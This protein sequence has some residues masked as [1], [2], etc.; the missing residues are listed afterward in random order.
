MGE[1]GN[2]FE[3]NAKEDRV[4]LAVALDLVHGSWNAGDNALAY[5]LGQAA[6]LWKD[7]VQVTSDLLLSQ[8]QL[9]EYI[10][11]A[12]AKFLE[13]HRFSIYAGGELKCA[14][15]PGDKLEVRVSQIR[16]CYPDLFI[17]VKLLNEE[18]FVIYAPKCSGNECERS[19]DAE[20]P[21]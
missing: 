7:G 9:T 1:Q 8:S 5:M 19:C 2:F 12:R 4:L 13:Q 15:V 3:P 17:N 21:C 20:A 11:Q 6:W 14:S 18:P 16:N 10:A